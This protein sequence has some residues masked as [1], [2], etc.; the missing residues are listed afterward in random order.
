MRIFIGI[1]QELEKAKEYIEQRYGSDG[2]FTEVGPFLSMVDA[3]NWLVY[4]KSMIAN[5]EE[6]IPKNQSDKDVLWF[7]F[8]CEVRAHD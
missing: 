4:L 7:G 1:T 6:V 3:L 8:S 2:C 5:F